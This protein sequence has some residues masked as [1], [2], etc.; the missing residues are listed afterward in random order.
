MFTIFYSVTADVEET[1]APTFSPVPDVEETPVGTFPSVPGVDEA[2]GGT[3]PS[4]PDVD[5]AS[6][7]TLPSFPDVDEAPGSTLPSVPYVEEI[8]VA[9]LSSAPKAPPTPL[10]SPTFHECTTMLSLQQSHVSHLKSHQQPVSQLPLSTNKGEDLSR[11]IRNWAKGNKITHSA[12]DKLLD[13]LQPVA[14]DLPRDSRTL[15][16]T[17]RNLQFTVMGNGVYHYFGLQQ[18]MHGMCF[19]SLRHSAITNTREN[20]M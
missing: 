2:P 15:L 3:L 19:N 13:I 4:V 5:E 18:H 7:G 6:G 20:T 17:P 14:P 10:L 9:M 8:P 16:Q 11:N 1:S 12:L